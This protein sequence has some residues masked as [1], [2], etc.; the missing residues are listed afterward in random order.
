M[1]NKIH[2][3]RIIQANLRNASTTMP[4]QDL[5]NKREQDAG[6]ERKRVESKQE[7]IDK[8]NF[9]TCQEIDPRFKDFVLMGDEIIVRLHKENYIKDISMIDSE[10][11]PV[12]DTWQHQVDARQ[13]KTDKADWQDSPLPYVYSGVIVSLSPTAQA[14]FSKQKKL[15]EESNKNAAKAYKIPQVGDTVALR[16][17]MFADYRFYF[18]SQ[19]VDYLINPKEYRVVY[20]EGYV[21]LHPTLVERVYKD[22]D[23]VLKE[24]SPYLTFKNQ[25]K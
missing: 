13:H 14:Y 2:K 3:K 15:I 16:H 5:Q 12:Y 4:L 8:Y 21:K 25:N 22:G 11:N 9:E 18:N 1:M 17:F 7:E 19:Q 23:K 20:W 10:G 6:L 24:M